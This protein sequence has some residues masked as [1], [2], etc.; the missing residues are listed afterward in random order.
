MA[1]PNGRVLF[2]AAQKEIPDRICK[3]LGLRF[4]TQSQQRRL[5]RLC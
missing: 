5:H 4:W 2:E 1:L 3:L